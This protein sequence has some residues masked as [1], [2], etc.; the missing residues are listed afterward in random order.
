M[1][2]AKVVV[3]IQLFPFTVVSCSFRQQSFV[4][5]QSCTTPSGHVCA[6]PCHSN[7]FCTMVGGAEAQKSADQPTARH[8]Q[9]P[10]QTVSMHTCK[11]PCRERPAPRDEARP[12]PRS[13]AGVGSYF[14]NLH[15]TLGPCWQT[16]H[17]HLHPP[18]M[19]AGTGRQK[20]PHS[21]ASNCWTFIALCP[22][23][24][25]LWHR[26]LSRE[27]LQHNDKGW[28][29]RGSRAPTPQS[30]IPTLRHSI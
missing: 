8:D 7:R 5:Q 15:F 3:T 20:R 1:K 16:A 24:R 10:Y 23:Q 4:C 6:A 28:A 13:R 30:S 9:R 18:A 25:S 17:G 26:S 27:K 11:R 22:C 12:P 21:T 19:G 29:H 2:P 14:D